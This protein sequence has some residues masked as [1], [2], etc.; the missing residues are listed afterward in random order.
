M[1]EREIDAHRLRAALERSP[2][3]LMSGPRQVGKSTLARQVVEPARSN[4]FDL[5]DPRDLARL[6]EPTLTLP[7]AH[8]TVVI[9][10]AQHRRDLFP[11]L[12][13]LVDED[14]RPGRFLVLGSASPDL[15]GLSSESLAGRVTVLELAG[16]RMADVGLSSRMDLWLR[17]G[18]PPS[19]LADSDQLSAAWRDDYIATFLERDLGG[20]G[21]RMPS[22]TMRRFWTMLAHYHGQVWNASELARSLGVSRPTVDRYLDALTDALVIRQLQPWF[23]NLAKRQVR[24][25]KVYVRDTGLLHRLLQIGDRDDLLGHPKAGASWEGFVIEQFLQAHPVVDPAFW[26]THGGAE[27][28]LVFGWERQRLGL[29]IKLTDRPGVTPSMRNALADLELDHILVAH[30]GSQSFRL[31]ERITAVATDELLTSPL[32]TFVTS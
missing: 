10:E 1:I 26:A 14:R 17:G 18:L 22:T 12:R 3:V 15:V 23:A 25:P 13:V 11:V 21:F 16:L 28:D 24:A 32:D 20:L 29:E 30:A 5:E 8:G 31:G 2:V 9:D 19:Y 7:G 6:G 4:L 27:I